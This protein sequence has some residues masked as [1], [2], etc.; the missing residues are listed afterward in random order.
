V[1]GGETLRR[2]IPSLVALMILL[3]LGGYAI[4]TNFSPARLFVGYV[5]TLN[6]DPQAG[7]LQ[8]LI[9]VG[10]VGGGLVMLG[11][12]GAGLAFIFYQ[13]PKLPARLAAPPPPAKAEAP[14]KPAA[15]GAGEA[16]PDPVP[17]SDT[18]SLVIFWVVLLALLVAFLFF[19]YAGAKGSPLPSLE[20]P[21]F[22]LPGEHVEGLP[23]WMAGPGDE[24]KAWQLFI[25]ILGGAI[26]GTMVAGVALAK[27]FDL[28]DQQVKAAAAR[29]A[30]RTVVDRLIASAEARIRDLLAPRAPRRRVSLFEVMFVILNLVLFLALVGVVVVYV[31]PSLSA[32][33]SVNKA[34]Q[35]TQAAALFTPTAPPTA[36]P[37]PLEVLQ[38]EFAALPKG[39]AEG[40]TATFTTAGCA[41]CHALEPDVKIVGPSQAGIAT[42]AAT[43][44]PGYSA[45]VYL[46]E[47]IILPN[48]YVVEGF[49]AGLMTP[50][51]KET[52]KP[53]EIADL[54]AFLMTLK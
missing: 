42:R 26:V 37:L 20:A 54:I 12:M 49:Q 2:Y 50:T 32:T 17:L 36:A 13:L 33:A 27:G 53:Q 10:G 44:K 51:F 7:Q 48:A 47:S 14:V 46:Y 45:E 28:L 41:A 21:V 38:K 40:G 9:L 24:L 29:K 35:A 1:I 22:K 11:G 43:R 8:A 52:L 23:A 19:N 6:P 5:P 16:R 30:P 31:I 18:R 4:Y 39:D 25:G 15:K 3:A 34:I